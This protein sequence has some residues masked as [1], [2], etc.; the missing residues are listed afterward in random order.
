MTDTAAKDGGR[1]LQGRD[2]K[3]EED[4]REEEKRAD[5]QQRNWRRWRVDIFCKA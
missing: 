3:E 4:K 1:D 5:R 2:G